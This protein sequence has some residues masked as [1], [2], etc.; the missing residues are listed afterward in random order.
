MKEHVKAKQAAIAASVMPVFL[1]LG[2]KSVTMDEVARQLKMSKKTLYKY[3]SDKNDLVAQT[4]QLGIEKDKEQIRA[5][6]SQSENAVEELL[7]VSKYI[8]QK[9]RQVHPS[10]FFDLEKYYPESWQL[11]TR[12]REEYTYQCMMDNLER[13]KQEGYYRTALPTAMIA[14]F[15]IA[16]MDAMFIMAMDLNNEQ[17]FGDMHL[18]A[19]SYHLHSITNEKGKKMLTQILDTL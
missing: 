1:R 6:N 10:I 2:F 19:V 8:A 5:L 18:E 13:G 7:L 16:V 17:P 15:F 4:I 3:F 14:R 9:T 12:F 11:F